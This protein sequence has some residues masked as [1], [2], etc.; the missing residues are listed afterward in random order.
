MSRTQDAVKQITIDPHVYV[1][2]TDLTADMTS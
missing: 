2:I 1:V